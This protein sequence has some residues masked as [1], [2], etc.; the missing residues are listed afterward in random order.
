MVVNITVAIAA[1]I[2]SDIAAIVSFSGW[3]I[4]A[5]SWQSESDAGEATAHSWNAI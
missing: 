2:T 4:R 3:L 1:T 5:S